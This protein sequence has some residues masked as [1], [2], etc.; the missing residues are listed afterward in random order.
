MAKEYRIDDLIG[1]E[2]LYH[3]GIKGQK[4]GRR[5]Y[6][7]EDGSLTPAGKERYDD[8]GPSEK[9]QKEYKIPEN[10][11]LHRLKLEDKYKA[12]GMSKQQAEQAAA[13]RIR[14]EQYAVAAA[15]VTVAACYAYN[16]HKN[17]TTDK[18]LKDV[19]FQRI[20][21]TA[22]P[23]DPVRKGPRYVSYDKRDNKKYT[24]IFGKELIGRKS[25]DEKI[26]KMAIKSSS[27]V[28]VASEKRAR[29]TFANLYKNDPEFRKNLQQRLD[30]N[31]IA[32]LGKPYGN[33]ALDIANGHEISDKRLKKMGYDAFNTMLVDMDDR[34]RSNASKFYD[35]LKK[36]GMQAV[37]DMND[38]KYSGYNTKNPL[39]LF[40]GDYSYNKKAIDES[41]IN[42]VA[43]VETNKLVA[44]SSLAYGAAFA[45]FYGVAPL[46]DKAT[47]DK[48]VYLYKK[49][50]PNTK[51]TESEI[52]KMYKEELKA[53]R[54]AYA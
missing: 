44:K 48:Q 43:K 37:G 11:S 30:E 20:L 38:K 31:R 33:A 52:R 28:K 9:K 4:W 10:K 16:K 14:G 42:S 8:D 39:I 19:E 47:I 1:S 15:A 51:M 5:R 41:F 32:L 54:S 23:D 17:Y 18:V 36:Q 29:D 7:N 21:K 35:A 24:G 46:I 49:E 34:G 50:H 27:D 6:Q 45:S 3:Y 26:Y 22:N 13:K 25:D 12:Q 2:E 53:A 40:D